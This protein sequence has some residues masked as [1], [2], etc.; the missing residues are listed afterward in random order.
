MNLD[1][2]DWLDPLSGLDAPEFPGLGPRSGLA[3]GMRFRVRTVGRV[4]GRGNSFG[5]VS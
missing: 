1:G 4:L 5:P 3:R 2:L